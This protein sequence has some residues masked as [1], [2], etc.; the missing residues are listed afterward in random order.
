MQENPRRKGIGLAVLFLLG[1]VGVATW[2]LITERAPSSSEPS[3]SERKRNSLERARDSFAAA[4]PSTGANG[5]VG[6]TPPPAA[7]TESLSPPDPAPPLTGSRTDT[8]E[9]AFDLENPDYSQ[10]LLAVLDTAARMIAE[11][12]IVPGSFRSTRDSWTD[13]MREL[14]GEI[15]TK[16]ERSWILRRDGGEWGCFL[17][18]VRDRPSNEPR[19]DWLS[20][21]APWYSDQSGRENLFATQV[22]NIGGISMTRAAENQSLT[23]DFEDEETHSGFVINAILEWQASREMLSNV[24]SANLP[25]PMRYQA[26]DRQLQVRTVDGP[27]V[28]KL[29]S[30]QAKEVSDARRRVLDAAQSRFQRLISR[31]PVR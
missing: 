12:E 22:G 13:P 23:L 15:P 25:G 31:C 11:D 1:L 26:W 7:S 14:A 8:S 10:L 24:A 29:T 3:S 5:P 19:V 30:E 27:T 4:P 2:F 16:W 9:P 6:S 17:K 21:E 20:L 18:Q 28:Q